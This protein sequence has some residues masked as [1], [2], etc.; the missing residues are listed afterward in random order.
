MGSTKMSTDIGNDSIVTNI[1]KG[2]YRTA[3]VFQKHG[4][5]FC[6]GGNWSLEAAC[7]MKGLSVNELIEELKQATRT[8]EIS[9]A[10]PFHEWSVDFLTDFIVNIHHHYLKHTIPQF[11]PVLNGFVDEHLKKDARL[12]HVQSSFR[13]LQK[14]ILPHLMEEEQDIFPYIRRL[15]HA[16]EDREPYAELLV[17]TMRRPIAKMMGSEHETVKDILDGFRQHTDNYTPPEKHCTSHRVVFSKL[18][19]L[20]HD[21]TQHMYLENQ[22]LFPKAIAMEKELLERKG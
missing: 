17:K 13:K 8:I 2:N 19:E 7:L 18:K 15:A 6:C 9:P 14:D 1:V 5:G 10:T 3:E 22:I 4:I 12:Y 21:L 20:D 16:Y 11:W